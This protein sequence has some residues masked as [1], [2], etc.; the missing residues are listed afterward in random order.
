MSVYY[1]GD[2][3][4]YSDPT[5]AIEHSGILGQKWGIRRFQY[6]DGSYTPEGRERYGIGQPREWD[7]TDE[8]KERILKSGSAAEVMSL[9]G[10]V[11]N[12]ELQQATTRLQLEN[13]IRNMADNEAK[14][15]QEAKPKKRDIASIMSKTADFLQSAINLYQKVDTIRSY[16]K[17]AEDKKKITP[18]MEYAQAMLLRFDKEK[19]LQEKKGDSEWFPAVK[20][21]AKV[22]D[23]LQKYQ[24]L[25]NIAEG[26]NGG[27]KGGK[28]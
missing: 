15:Q 8:D 24:Q 7:G 17:K 23:Q 12:Q 9:Q 26:K 19:D 18:A 28:G 25:M 11:S 14:R 20:D 3:E 1:I 5:E 13:N 2:L 16:V 10:K 6:K 21:M 27:G 4:F 22:I